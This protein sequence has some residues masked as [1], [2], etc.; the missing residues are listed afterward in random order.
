MLLNGLG[1]FYV[2]ETGQTLRLLRRDFFAEWLMGDIQ[3]LVAVTEN[4]QIQSFDVFV[5]SNR[6][7]EANYLVYCVDGVVTLLFS[8]SPSL[9]Q[10]HSPVVIDASGVCRDV[11]II[12]IGADENWA[13][14]LYVTYIKDDIEGNSQLCF[15]DLKFYKPF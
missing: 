2:D 14:E 9:E 1:L 7:S 10:W 3:D 6:L 4:Q 11:H 5:A 8:H 13:Y 15:Q 12:P